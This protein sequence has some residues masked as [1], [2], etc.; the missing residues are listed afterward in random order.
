MRDLGVRRMSDNRCWEPEGVLGL[1]CG[2]HAVRYDP[3]G[4]PKCAIHLDP[5]RARRLGL[6]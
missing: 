6:I 3:Q 4:V 1:F 5:E 2:S